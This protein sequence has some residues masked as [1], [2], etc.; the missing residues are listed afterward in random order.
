M[1]VTA[2]SRAERP[3]QASEAWSQLGGIAPVGVDVLK[4]GSS[5]SVVRLTHRAGTVV[6]K[7]GCTTKLEYE[8]VGLVSRPRVH[9]TR[10]DVAMEE[11]GS[12]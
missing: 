5:S 1:T 6:G 2:P 3:E 11:V 4:D 8:E 7:W 10:I 9:A 12:W